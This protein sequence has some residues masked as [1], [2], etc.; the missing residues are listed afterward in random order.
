MAQSRHVWKSINI[1]EEEIEKIAVKA[2]TKHKKIDLMEG[3]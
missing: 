3:S 2:D 1:T